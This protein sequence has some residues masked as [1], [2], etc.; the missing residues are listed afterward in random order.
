MFLL[1]LVQLYTVPIVLKSLGAS[2][3]GLY[4]VVGGVVTMFSFI[5]GSLSSGS[6]RFIAY[7]LG[8]D[9]VRLLKQTFDTTLSIYIVFAIISFVVLELAGV[10]FLNCQMNIPTDKLTAANWV[11]QFSLLAFVINLIIIPYIATVIAH[12][13]MSLFAYLSILECILKLGVAIVLQFILENQLVVYA[14]LIFVVAILVQGIYFLYCRFHFVECR[15]YRLSWN[16]KIGMELLTYSG[17]NVVGSLAIISRQQGLNVLLN[18]FFGTILN[19]AHSIAQ[20]ING[21]LTQFVNNLYMATRPQITKLYAAGDSKEMWNL[22]FRSAKLAFYLLMLVSIPSVIEMNAILTLW[23]GSVP[24]YT[25]EISI[26]MIISMLIETQV[27]QIIAAFQAANKIKKYQLY[28]ST[29]LLLN[30]P[31]TYLLLKTIDDIPLVPYFVSI[32]LSVLYA[33]SI[34]WQAKVVIQLDLN[35]YIKQVIFKLSLVFGIAFFCIYN[36]ST[37]MAPSFYRIACTY[38]LSIFLIPLIV[39]LIG[40][41]HFERSFCIR[42]VRNKFHL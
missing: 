22:V 20:Q 33:G 19:A 31:I 28:S 24:Q 30:I 32:L 40:L 4:Y 27:N 6:Q 23:L 7:A 1:I 39:W 11:Y 16:S 5:G 35:R 38:S 29:I 12:E 21:V 42:L 9:D 18:L 37:L 14:I 34:L 26:L 13:R 25:T 2:D 10:W 15:N 8:K 17:W 3:Y 36:I 41:D